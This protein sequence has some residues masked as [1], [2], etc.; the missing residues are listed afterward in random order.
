M[1]AGESKDHGLIAR[2]PRWQAGDL[3]DDPCPGVVGEEGRVLS[4]TRPRG[5]SGLAEHG[6]WV[7]QS[8]VTGAYCGKGEEE[9]TNAIDSVAAQV[10]SVDKHPDRTSHAVSHTSS[11][12]SMM[13]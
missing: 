6:W 8:E 11:R 10:P 7:A 4:S 12:G 9:G 3:L 13:N 1:P 5:G 2:G